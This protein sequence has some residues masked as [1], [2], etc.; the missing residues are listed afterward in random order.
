MVEPIKE[1]KTG[2]RVKAKRSV[3][4]EQRWALFHLMSGGLSV[5][6]ELEAALGR[7]LEDVPLSEILDECD[8][9]AGEYRSLSKPVWCVY[10][11][12]LTDVVPC[13]NCKMKRRGNNFRV[14]PKRQKR[15]TVT[16]A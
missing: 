12:G 11:G 10:C 2:K 13:P 16:D 6:A 5:K 15:H 14:R 4:W 9:A 7:T 1:T 8:Q 3:T